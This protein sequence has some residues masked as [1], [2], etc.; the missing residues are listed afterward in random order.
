MLYKKLGLSSTKEM[1]AKAIKGKYACPGYNFNNM[2]QLQAIITACI[3]TKSPVV[4]Q[5][6]PP[7]NGGGVNSTKPFVGFHGYWAER[8]DVIEPHF[9]DAAALRALG[10]AADA[11]GIKLI[12]DVVVNHAGIG[13][14][15]V[16]QNPA[17]FRTGNQCGSD[18]LT[19]C[20][21]GLPDFKQE[22]AGVNDFLLGT[23]TFLRNTASIDGLRMDT[24]KHVP[25]SFWAQFFASTSPASPAQLWTV[26]EVFSSDVQQVARYVDS[27]GSP[28]VFDFPLRGAII[29][30]LAKGG[31][32]SRLADLFAQDTRYRDPAK[33]STFLDNHDV[34]RFASEAEA[35]G[36]APGEATQRLDLAL[37][38]LYTARGIPVVYYG[39]EF[40]MRGQGDSYNL[41]IGQS[42]RD[43]MDF[44][45]LATS[46]LDERLRT[47]ADARKRYPSLRRG[48]QRTLSAPGTSCQ[49]PASV[50][51]PAADFGDRLFARGTFNGW[52]SP[53]PESQRF[54][55]LGGRQY[56]AAVPIS[57][58]AHEFKVAA[59][60]WTPEFAL[61]GTDTLLGVPA[62]LAAAP[63]A[64]ANSRIAIAASGCY[65]FALNAAS[66]VNPVLTVTLKATEP[67]VLVKGAGYSEDTI[68][69]ADLVRARGGR[70]AALDELPGRSTR[71]IIERI[72]ELGRRG[73][74]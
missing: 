1:Y 55:N 67:D 5:V 46:A 49:P 12:V 54:V 47:L 45:R 44:T 19:L 23:I 3:E 7:G 32:T 66:T 22:V 51:D 2:E 48:L 59:A 74:L 4:L 18:D 27:V 62:T 52:T 20:L 8:F 40:G 26:G 35:A 70:V 58:G 56:E 73:L 29:D 63:G 61:V 57:A 21:G 36:I 50:L 14:G 31:S 13:S 65:T 24:M 43:D 34:W 11:A 42:S 60:D 53:P 9:G 25:D 30:S 38:L 68:V 64:G 71:S 39:T 37:S 41:P 16:T 6:A 69:G 17:W 72:L 15:L 10:A 33:L 28:S